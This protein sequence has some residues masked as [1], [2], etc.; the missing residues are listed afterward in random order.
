MNKIPSETPP[1]KSK[2]VSWRNIVLI[3]N[4]GDESGWIMGSQ[5]EVFESPE[6]KVLREEQAEEVRRFLA[7]LPSQ[8]QDIIHWKFG[9]YGKP[10]TNKAIGKRLGCSKEAVRQRLKVLYRTLS[11]YIQEENEQKPADTDRTIDRRL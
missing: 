4:L 8:A 5:T 2:T 1:K 11:R 6:S 7:M 10:L 3:G 9:F